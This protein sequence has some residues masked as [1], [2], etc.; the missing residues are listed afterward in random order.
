MYIFTIVITK[1]DKHL[2]P[3]TEIIQ[4]NSRHDF[5][6][7]YK[8]VLEQCKA[9]MRSGDIRDYNISRYEHNKAW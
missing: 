1:W 4:P 8:T 7:T 5:E 6:K 3:N 9:E 2:V